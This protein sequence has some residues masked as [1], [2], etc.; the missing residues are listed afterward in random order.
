M[1]GSEPRKGPRAGAAA[2]M[3]SG[4][5]TFRELDPNRDRPVLV[6]LLERAVPRDYVLGIL[7]RWLAAGGVLGG[8]RG[9]ELLAV[10]RLDDLG[11]SE[12]WIGAIRVLPKVRR[13]GWGADLTRYALA[14]ARDRGISIVRL[15][16]DDENR[17]S[18]ALASSLGFRPVAALA[19]TVGLAPVSNLPP[20]SVRLRPVGT[21]EVA[22]I[23]VGELEGVRRLHGQMLTTVPRPQRFARATH[24]RLRWEAAQGR[25]YL[26]GDD[27]RT[28]LC[29]SS[30]PGVAAARDGRRFRLLAP[31]GSEAGEVFRAWSLPTRA[32]RGEIEGFLPAEGPLLP[33]MEHLGWRTGASAYWGARVRLY[34][35]RT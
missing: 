31:L 33:E 7:D 17:P 30:P 19:H 26:W 24:D 13:Q 35:V 2:P 4:D 9:E 34:E 16:I 10:Q 3:T 29:L 12:G 15:T 6:R 32:E 22:G 14:V 11:A 27:P 21:T 8:F 23:P 1:S 28:G 25:L 18:R 20:K 5:R